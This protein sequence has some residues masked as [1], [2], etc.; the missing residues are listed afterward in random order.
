[1]SDYAYTFVISKEEAKDILEAGRK[2]IDKVI[3]YVYLVG[4]RD[5]RMVL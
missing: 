3:K 2:F 1:M 4:E 5:P